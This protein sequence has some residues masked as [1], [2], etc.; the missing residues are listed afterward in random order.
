MKN[1]SNYFANRVAPYLFLGIAIA[2]LV[3]FA[4]ILSYLFLWGLVIGAIIFIAVSAKN[5]FFPSKK[6]QY[7]RNIVIEH[8][9]ID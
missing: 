3:G 6:R 4:I 1:Y 8:D 9:E 7:K 5:K 2:I